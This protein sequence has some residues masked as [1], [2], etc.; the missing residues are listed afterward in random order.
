MKSQNLNQAFN[1]LNLATINV[2]K[3][4]VIQEVN[5]QLKQLSLDQ[6]E[7]IKPVEVA[8][9]ALN[10]LPSLYALSSDDLKHHLK[11]AKREYRP[12]VAVAVRQGIA[13]IQRDSSRCSK[14]SDLKKR[15][16][17]KQTQH[18]NS[19]KPNTPKARKIAYETAKKLRDVYSKNT[20]IASSKMEIN[21]ATA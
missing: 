3:I 5:R 16:K 21:L 14:L 15:R 12:L 11:Q 10:R 20:Q 1:D 13:V 19:V 8:T 18:S 4:L 7:Y 6:A 2:M 17:S 9:F